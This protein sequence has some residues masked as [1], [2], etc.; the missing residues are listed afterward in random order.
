MK[1]S[2][3]LQME[4]AGGLVKHLGLSMYRGAVP[5]IAEL[6]SNSW[7][8]DATKVAVSIP[9]S[10]GLKDQEIKVADDGRGMTWD[11]VASAYLVVGRDRRKAEGEK[12]PRGR[13]VMGRKGLGKLA[14][15]GIARIVDVRTI[16]SGWVTHF[17]MDFEQMTKAG[18]AE[19]VKSTNQRSS[20]TL[21]QTSLTGP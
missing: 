19:L 5:A 15:F 7:D 1:T 14:G 10:V 8:A 3:R 13:P 21:K 4:Y 17:R 12:T 6:I 2:R 20:R 9:F 16:R 11:E 18:Q